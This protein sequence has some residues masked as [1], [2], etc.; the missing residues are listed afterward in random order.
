[1]ASNPPVPVIIMQT[2]RKFQRGTIAFVLLMLG[3]AFTT[4]HCGD[5]PDE[6][7]ENL[8]LFNLY[9]P[10]GLAAVQS[11]INQ[12]LKDCYT[13]CGTSFDTS[14]DGTIQPSE[15]VDYDACTTTCDTNCSSSAVFGFF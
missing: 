6:T 15:Q 10:T 11:G 5:D 14:G 12:P 9:C 4:M 2:R 8:V 1:M 13:A 3:V 7:V